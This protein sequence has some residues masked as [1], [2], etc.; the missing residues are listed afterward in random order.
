MMHNPGQILSAMQNFMELEDDGI[1]L[2]G[3]PRG[4]GQ[5]QAGDRLVGRTISDE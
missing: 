3:T 1:F 5:V 2:S 4:V